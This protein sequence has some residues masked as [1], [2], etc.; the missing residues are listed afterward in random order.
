M[1]TEERIAI[2]KNKAQKDADAKAAAEDA[3]IKE[4]KKLETIIK[5]MSDQIET[6]ITLANT[7][8]EN[9]IEIPR[10]SQWS[11]DYDSGK[12]YGYP[13]EFIAEGIRHHTG[14]IRRKGNYKYIGIDNGGCCGQY[15]FWTNGYDVFA[16]HEARREDRRVARI[17]D[18]EQFIKE[19]PVFAKAFLAWIDSLDE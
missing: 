12:E 7:C 2:I 14:L 9:G 15:D 8:V 16:V 6:I 1:T 18:M 17:R 19:F 10:K 5:G 13:Y 11:N 4:I 3:K